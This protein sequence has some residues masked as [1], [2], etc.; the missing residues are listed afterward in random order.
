MPRTGVHDGRRVR[1]RRSVGWALAAVVVIGLAG[2]GAAAVA[3]RF[4]V[5]SKPGPMAL[6]LAAYTRGDWA[7]ASAKAKERLA[8]EPDDAEAVRLLARAAARLG[9][10]D[11]AQALFGRL[12]PAA[13]AAEDYALIGG[14][15]ARKGKPDLALDAWTVALGTDPAQ[16]EA[17]GAMVEFF[18]KKDE[19]DRAADLAGRLAA[20]E[21]PGWRSRG[22]VALADLRAG[23]GDHADAA[24]RYLQA[25][26]NVNPERL[27][28]SAWEPLPLPPVAEVRK[29]LARALLRLGKAAE[30]QGALTPLRVLGDD[31]EAQWLLSRAALQLGDL[32]GASAALDRSGTYR[33]EHPLEPEP[34]PFVG[35]ARC[36][37]CHR[38]VARALDRTRHARTF[39]RPADLKTIPLPPPDT[40]DPADPRASHTFRRGEDSL[41]LE[42]RVDGRTFRAVVDFAFGSGDRGMSL[43]G[44]EEPSGTVRELRLSR[45]G[46]A[47]T[48]A[49][50]DLTTGHNPHPSSPDECLGRP[51]SPGSARGCLVCH[52]TDP[53]S[54]AGG[55]GPA[56]HDRAIGCERCHGPGGHHVAAA[57]AGFPDLAVAAEAGRAS[58]AAVVRLC[59]QCHSPRDNSPVSPDDP[60]S[61]RFQA[62]T[63]T[64]SRCFTGSGQALG[65]LTCHDPHRNARPDPAY[66]EAKCRT[67]HT[68]PGVVAADGPP[69][70]STVCPVNAS[71]GCLKCHM[72][73]VRT[74]LIP[75]SPFTDHHIRVRRGDGAAGGVGLSQG[76]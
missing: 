31:P 63:L 65:C 18:R 23:L 30:A 27:P 76:R 12:G 40:R 64:W 1:R 42:T 74:A 11:S 24:A 73:V 39:F 54:A 3:W 45:Y 53:R 7:G 13:W 15:L 34:A 52:T 58:P 69:R 68:P 50:W 41:R 44:R 17:L 62:T 70:A 47:K 33:D 10:D 14:V 75:H 67:C 26:K 71:A 36:A 43:V 38:S 51:L 19:L 22:L 2:A 48:P 49:G 28:A 5:F 6:G 56:S 57:Q 61:V 20:L 60:A 16:P 9:R 72:P 66:Y 25:L 8:E 4:G 55:S 29:R 21:Q 59:G 46:D 37:G 35:S 32:A